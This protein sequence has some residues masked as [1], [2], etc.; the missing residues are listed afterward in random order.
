MFVKV[1][2]RPW[3]DLNQGQSVQVTHCHINHFVINTHRPL[4]EHKQPHTLTKSTLIA[5]VHELNAKSE[6]HF[7]ENTKSCS[8]D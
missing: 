5:T 2:C 8:T 1:E 6:G 3:A 7:H 4:K